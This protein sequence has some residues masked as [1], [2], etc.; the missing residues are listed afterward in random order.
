MDPL[1]FGIRAC[2]VIQVAATAVL[3]FAVGVLIT[4]R[5]SR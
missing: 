5:W 4:G 1:E 3:F 2:L